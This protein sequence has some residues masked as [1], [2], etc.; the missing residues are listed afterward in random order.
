M[1]YK[2]RSISV[3]PEFSMETLRDRRAKTD[4]LQIWEIRETPALTTISE[5]LS[6]TIDG[7]RHSMKNKL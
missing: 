7:E 5:N 2:G 6:E 1:T 3:R 4:I